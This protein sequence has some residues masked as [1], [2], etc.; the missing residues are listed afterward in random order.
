MGHRHDRTGLF[1]LGPVEPSHQIVGQ[2]HGGTGD[3][4]GGWDEYGKLSVSWVNGLSELLD[5]DNLGAT[6]VNGR[7]CVGEP[8]PPDPCG[9]G[10]S[11]DPCGA[12]SECCS[13]K[14]KGKSGSKTC[15]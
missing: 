11:G 4:D 9:L 7:N 12:D 8:P 14:C 2:L 5:P 13:G 15:R 3:C 10:K 6:F 1:R